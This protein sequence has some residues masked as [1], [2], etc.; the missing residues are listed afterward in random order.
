VL[1]LEIPPLDILGPIEFCGALALG[2][3][4]YWWRAS[5]ASCFAQGAG[6]SG[7]TTAVFGP[8]TYAVASVRWPWVDSQLAACDAAVGAFGR[9][10]VTWTAEHPRST[11]MRLV[12]SS[13]FRRSSRSSSCSASPWTGVGYLLN[14]LHARRAADV[15]DLRLSAGPGTCVYFH[16]PT[17]DHYVAC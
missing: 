2:A 15:G 7:G 12:Y 14:P 8:L 3:L 16:Q 4:Y 1:G 11:V 9:S 10:A 5:N 6:D 17:P 13:V